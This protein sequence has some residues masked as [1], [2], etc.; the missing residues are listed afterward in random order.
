MEIL[1]F[2]TERMRELVQISL[3]GIAFVFRRGRW[4]YSHRDI[5]IRRCLLDRKS[6]QPHLVVGLFLY[7]TEILLIG[8]RV[9]GDRIQSFQLTTA[10]SQKF[11]FC[12]VQFK[13][14]YSFC[15]PR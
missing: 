7:L 8:G 13:I 12:M 5:Y 11:F 6:K 14:G 2:S 4:L 15:P 10:A 3:E 1:Y 9:F